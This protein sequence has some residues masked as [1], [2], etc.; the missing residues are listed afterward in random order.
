[1]DF[2]HRTLRK[3]LIPHCDKVQ[4]KISY[5]EY[6]Q[7]HTGGIKILSKSQKDELSAMQNQ[8]LHAPSR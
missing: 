4:H 7:H 3:P 5:L 8:K 2:V 1:M 6:S